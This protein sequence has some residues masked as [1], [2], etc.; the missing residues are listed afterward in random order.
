[1]LNFEGYYVSAVYNSYYDDNAVI[2]RLNN[3]TSQ[4][5]KLENLNLDDNYKFVNAIEEVIAMQDEIKPYDFVSIK[6]Y[7]N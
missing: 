4:S 5:M 3:P 1:M 6:V 2:V 7:E